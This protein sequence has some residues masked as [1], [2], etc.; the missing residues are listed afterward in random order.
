MS[1]ANAGMVTPA[2]RRVA[3]HRRVPVGRAG[4]LTLWLT[5]LALAFSPRGSRPAHRRSVGS[6]KGF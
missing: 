5:F 3:M 2:H 4:G 1:L 6:G